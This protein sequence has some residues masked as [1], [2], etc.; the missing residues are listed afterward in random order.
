MALRRP[1]PP[2]FWWLSFPVL[3]ASTALAPAQGAAPA[4]GSKGEK[5]RVYVGTYTGG[6][7]EGIY[8]LE[9]DLPSGALTTRG[10]AGRAVNPSFLAIHP[11]RRFLY[12]VSEGRG[13]G[14]SNGGAVDAFAIDPAQGTQTA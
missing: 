7:S 14:G 6:K 9:L 2:H 5:L 10:V 11:E 13:S 12:A 4:E 1:A 3:C 8:L